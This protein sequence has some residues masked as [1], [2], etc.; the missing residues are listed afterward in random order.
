[1]PTANYFR[2]LGCCY[3]A[4]A[5]FYFVSIIQISSL[6]YYR[7]VLIVFK[8]YSS[9]FF[10]LEIQLCEP[11]KVC[12][13]NMKSEHNCSPPLSSCFVQLS[14]LSA[15]AYSYQNPGSESLQISIQICL[16]GLDLALR[17][18]SFEP[19]HRQYLPLPCCVVSFS[20][21]CYN[22]TV[23]QFMLPLLPRRPS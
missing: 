20:Y 22:T 19:T 14:P 23:C 6:W 7:I 1:M 16:G 5:H 11:S 12:G 4:D 17:L 13:E 10:Q 9:H 2:D 8:L 18:G 15:K 3:L 21:P